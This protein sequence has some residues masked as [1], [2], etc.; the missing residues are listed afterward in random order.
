MNEILVFREGEPE[1]KTVVANFATSA[2]VGKTH[3]LEHYNLDVTIRYNN[4][5]GERMMSKIDDIQKYIY[6]LRGV[7]V[8][9]DEKLAELYGVETRALN[10]A[11][12]RNIQRFPSEFMFQLTDA[13]GENVKAQNMPIS[14]NA[15]RSQTVTIKKGRG[16]HRKYLPYAF[17]EQG[18]AMLSAVLKSETA[19]KVS[20][21][22]MN[23]F[24]S[25]RRFLQS[26]AQIFQRLDSLEL[27][28]SQTDQ[29]VDRVLNAIEEK[30]TLPKQGI[31]FDGQVFDAWNFVSDLVR[32]AKKSIILIDNYIDDTVLSLFSKKE[33]DVRVTLLTKKIS[34]QL[35]TD[36]RKFNEQYEP[37]TLCTFP[38]SHDRFL[39]ID[40]KDLYHVGASLKDLGNKW[41]AFSKMDISTVSLLDNLKK[42]NLSPNSTDSP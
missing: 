38:N 28:Q 24:V 41:F 9:L 18:V 8:M 31:F 16:Q 21:Q 17:T 4:N 22:I 13:E 11:V 14:S 2:A 39:I 40:E 20:I 6:S 3:Q 15:F 23:A 37:L 36:V 1:R 34:P 12:K 29:K 33:K 10:Q 30:T 25:M 35:E 26:N 7:E 32:S 27:R 5:K 42:L 19:I